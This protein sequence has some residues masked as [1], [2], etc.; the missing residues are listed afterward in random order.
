[1]KTLILKNY[2]LNTIGKVLNYP[3]AFQLGR[4]KNRFIRV[5]SDKNSL[6]EGSRQEMAKDL[7]DKDDTRIPLTEN[8]QYKFTKENLEKFN[9]EYTKLMNEDCIID[10]GPALEADI[11]TIKQMINNSAVTLLAHEVAQVEEVL[12]ALNEAKPVAEKKPKA[13]K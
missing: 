13:K 5:L 11:P 8:G 2:Q 4:V 10:V 9:E 12:E 7:S 3:L 6:I 1:M